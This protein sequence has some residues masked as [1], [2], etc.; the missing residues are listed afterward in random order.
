MLGDQDGSS[1][2]RYNKKKYDPDDKK[3][4]LGLFKNKGID[5]KKANY[6]KVEEFVLKLQK[7]LDIKDYKKV[8]FL[9]V[10]AGAIIGFLSG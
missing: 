9:V 4:A 2:L 7:E 10:R 8:L 1:F 3:Y 5:I 6:N